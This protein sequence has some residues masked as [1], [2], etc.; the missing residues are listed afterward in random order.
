MWMVDKEKLTL[1]VHAPIFR[2]AIA[3]LHYISFILEFAFEQWYRRQFQLFSILL[4]VAV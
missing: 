4:E 2:A 1:H 3:M